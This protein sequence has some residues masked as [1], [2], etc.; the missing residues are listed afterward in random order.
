MSKHVKRGVDQIHFDSTSGGQRLGLAIDRR[1]MKLK[2][3]IAL[4]SWIPALVSFLLLLYIGGSMH[5]QKMNGY[6]EIASFALVFIATRWKKKLK[7]I[8]E[9]KKDVIHSAHYSKVPK[10]YHDIVN[11]TN[12]R[13]TKDG[14]YYLGND[15]STGAEAHCNDDMARIHLILFGTTGGGKTEAILSFCSNFLLQGSGFMIVDGKGDTLLFSK[16]FSV[17][18]AFNRTDDLYVLSFMPVE[19]SSLK[20]LLKHSNT[21]NFFVDSTVGEANEIIGGLLPND[22][23]GGG[24][25]WSGRAAT[26]IESINDA[27]YWLQENGYLTLD[28]DVYRRYFILDRFA[29]LAFNEDIPERYRT[30]L[31]TILNSVNYKLPPEAQP[32]ETESQ[33]QYITMQYTQTF[34]MLA[35]KYAHVTVTQCP[36]ISMTDIILRRRI[37]LVLLP[38][39]AQ[40]AQ[41][42]RNLGRIVIA[43]A[44][45]TSAKALGNKL[46]GSHA[47]IIDGKPTSSVSS[48][49]MIFDEFG[50]YSVK[51]ASNLPAMLRSLNIVTIFAGQD[52]RAFEAGD[53]KEAATI[54]GT[55]NI[56]VALKL[57]CDVTYDKFN[58]VLSEETVLV[59]DSYERDDS[60]IFF[61]KYKKGKNVRAEKKAVLSMS[62]LKD[63]GAG[64]ATLI[65]QSSVNRI[66]WFFAS[67]VP[68]PMMR[69]NHFLEIKAPD[70]S[71][72]NAMRT[73]VNALHLGY[74]RFL[75]GDWQKEFETIK[76]Y[77]NSFSITSDLKKFTDISAS[78]K[79]KMCEVVE[80]DET[81][82]EPVTAYD[83]ITTA[84]GLYFNKLE[85]LD[86]KIANKIRKETAEA[87]GYDDDELLSQFEIT[88]DT[89]GMFENSYSV[90]ADLEIELQDTPE[91]RA[92]FSKI[93]ND[94]QN[95]TVQL[96][97][98]E[99]LSFKSLPEMG[100][101]V[102]TLENNLSELETLLMVKHD[103]DVQNKNKYGKLIAKR[104]VIDMGI[105]SNIA[106]V[107]QTKKQSNSQV[108][109]DKV[110]KQM[111]S[112]LK[113]VGGF[114]G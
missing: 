54:F 105:K 72:V 15:L 21:I 97:E 76:T 88:D 65:V 93:E 75:N 61:T 14:L 84:L 114:N 58:K 112:M 80:K 28:P 78:V 53:D 92:V 17:C 39:L 3:E 62:D 32:T 48:F 86:N 6:P 74:K 24:D 11:N 23:S 45:N 52:Y 12:P 102:F 44:R 103:V 63:Q 110:K 22:S 40:S 100:L 31:W 85:V 49:C 20:T 34:N 56:K 30:G 109:K 19:N 108:A 89:E 99:D 113:Q 59:H 16:L 1:P 68:A 66:G 69:L 83:S 96:K 50:A 29:E 51:S 47:E 82:N 79:K 8:N 81:M 94:I 71:R 46:E 13:E 57:E 10:K 5:M 27:L 55:C 77:S 4:A 70:H 2:Y 73:G 91:D 87:N 25:V 37:L 43:L 35:N 95:K 60:S 111:Q 104:L 33:F 7:R 107:T 9:K 26:G 38:A 18:R 101:D 90:P 67:H 36:D 42:V 64:E 106:S 98:L 41:N